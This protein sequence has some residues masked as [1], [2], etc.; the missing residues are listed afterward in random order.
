VR[1]RVRRCCEQE[2]V[3]DVSAKSLM[4]VLAKRIQHRLR[5]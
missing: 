1:S 3:A 5:R 2:R 4:F